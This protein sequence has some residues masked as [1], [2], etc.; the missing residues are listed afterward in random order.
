MVKYIHIY[1]IRSI[2]NV[3]INLKELRIGPRNRID[4]DLES[5]KI[6]LTNAGRKPRH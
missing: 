5:A 6:F 3:L 1:N 4:I 2:K